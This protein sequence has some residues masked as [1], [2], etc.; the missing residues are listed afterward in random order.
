MENLACTRGYL[1]SKLQH[2]FLTAMARSNLIPGVHFGVRAMPMLALWACASAP[3]ETRSVVASA[4]AAPAAASA[5]RAAAPDRDYLVFVGSE[6]TDR[7]ALVRFGPNG[8]RV[9]R[10][11]MTGIMPADV[12]GPHGIAVSP[13]GRFYYVTTAHGTAYGVLW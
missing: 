10:E 12:D 5:V 7:I 11:T 1:P 4:A 8:A 6:A 13:D 2:Y 3:R 9:E